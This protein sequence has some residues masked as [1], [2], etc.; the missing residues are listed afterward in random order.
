LGVVSMKMGWNSLKL[1]AS[2]AWCHV[3]PML[4]DALGKYVCSD[5]YH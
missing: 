1:N 5:S 4:I 2:D 3:T